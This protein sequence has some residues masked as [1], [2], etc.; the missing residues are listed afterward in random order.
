MRMDRKVY[1][2][3][4]TIERNS[5]HITWAWIQDYYKKYKRF[6]KETEFY[7]HLVDDNLKNDPKHYNK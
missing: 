2:N 4:M 7:L 6:P 3:G 1:E 5:H